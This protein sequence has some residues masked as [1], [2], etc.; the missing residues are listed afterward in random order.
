MKDVAPRTT[1]SSLVRKCFRQYLFDIKSFFFNFFGHFL[2]FIKYN[3]NTISH[4]LL[5][6]YLWYA[7]M[8]EASK[9]WTKNVNHIIWLEK[10]KWT[11]HKIAQWKKNTAHVLISNSNARTNNKIINTEC[12][13]YIGD[14]L[15]QITSVLMT[16]IDQNM[17]EK[18][19][20]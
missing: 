14:V 1:N 19:I 8:H 3:S 2:K 10:K 4:M 15:G 18:K 13:L 16:L 17:L 11:I 20:T 6:C 9:K 12:S 5:F 7:W